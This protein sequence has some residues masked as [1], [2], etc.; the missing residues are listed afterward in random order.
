M[1]P[2]GQL[3]E[4]VTFQV[5]NSGSDSHG[6]PVRTWTAHASNVAA[7]VTPIRAKESDQA[8]GIFSVGSIVVV[9][10]YRTDITPAMR[11]VWRSKNYAISGAPI[12]V[13]AR[14]EGLEM[15]C[16]LSPGAGD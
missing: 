8:D 12:D 4:R 6:Q 7:R 2:A 13:G 10:R 14:K 1:L 5:L 9:V 3:R 16:I 15:L 11:V